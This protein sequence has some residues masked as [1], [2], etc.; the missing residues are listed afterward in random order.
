MFLI[1]RNLLM[2]LIERNLLMSLIER[3]FYLG[4]CSKKEGQCRSSLHAERQIEN[5]GKIIWKRVINKT[6]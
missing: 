6:L 5:G 1:E 4:A 3:N 2:S